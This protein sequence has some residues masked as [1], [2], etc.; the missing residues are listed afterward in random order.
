MLSNTD[1]KVVLVQRQ[2]LDWNLMTKPLFRE[3]SK[4]FCRLWGRPEDQAYRMM[5]LW[6]AAF[7]VGYFETR[8]RVKEI[9]SA[10]IMSLDGIQHVPY[11]N[12]ENIPNLP[13]LYVFIDD[14]DW[15]APDLANILLSQDVDLYD[16]ILWRVASIGIA[17]QKHAI[18]SWGMNGRCMTNNYAINSDWLDGL[19]RLP[20]VRQHG[21]AVKTFSRLDR[22]TQLDRV[23]SV[24]NKNP[25]SSVTMESDLKGEFHTDRLVQ[26]LKVYVAKIQRI[27]PSD[28]TQ[29]SWA[30]P[31]IDQTVELFEKI[32]ASRKV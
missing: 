30:A 24:T 22:Q 20:E 13:A 5:D 14:D 3:S 4:A 32:L 25:C 15:L 31:Y 8:H 11:K 9:A 10:N 16:G 17:N 29:L 26:M 6:D 27:S 21:E 19:R 12:Y 18:F 1:K 7:R 28:L 23:L 2:T